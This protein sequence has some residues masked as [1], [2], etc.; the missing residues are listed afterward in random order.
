MLQCGWRRVVDRCDADDGSHMV[1]ESCFLGC[2]DGVIHALICFVRVACQRR[3]RKGGCLYVPMT[4]ARRAP[5][6]AM[7]K[8]RSCGTVMEVS[9]LQLGDAKHCFEL[10]T[11]EKAN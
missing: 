2:V 10:G 6:F 9:H 11:R 7:T 4:M 3:R 1:W 8:L 5:L